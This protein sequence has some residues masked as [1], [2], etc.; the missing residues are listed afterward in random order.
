MEITRHFAS[1]TYIVYNNKVLLQHHLKLK[2]W[3][4]VGGHLDRDELPQDCAIREAK[5]EAGLD[6]TL[7][8]PDK[9]FGFTETR[10]LTRAAHMNL[11]KINEFH[12]HICFVYFATCDTDQV[13]PQEGESKELVWVGAEEI[14]GLEAPENVKA[15][16]K[17]ALEVLGS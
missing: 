4:P 17:H 7:H 6:I 3:V 9:D 5:E 10:Q 14:D 16:A 15:H 2:F 8:D 1:S 11:H 13:A 12:E